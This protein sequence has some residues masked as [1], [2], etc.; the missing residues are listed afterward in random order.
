[1]V[2]RDKLVFRDESENRIYVTKEGH[3]YGINKKKEILGL[4]NMILLLESAGFNIGRLEKTNGN[5]ML[6]INEETI[7]ED[8]DV[9]K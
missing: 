2:I 1:M 6:E 3:W 7:Q 4:N 9:S 5:I 8:F